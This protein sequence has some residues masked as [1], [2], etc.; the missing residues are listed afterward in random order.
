MAILTDGFY[1]LSVAFAIQLES[2]T[3]HAAIQ[4][5]PW[6][7][8]SPRFQ[9]KHAVLAVYIAGMALAAKSVTRPEYTP[10]MYA[11]L[12]IDNQQVGF[13]K[14]QLRQDS[15]SGVPNSTVSLINSVNSTSTRLFAR[16]DGETGVQDLSGVITDHKDPKLTIKYNIFG[17]HIPIVEISSVFLDAMAT[18]ARPDMTATDAYVNSL[19]ISATATV[20]VHQVTSPLSWKHLIRTVTLLWEMLASGGKDHEIDF[21]MFYDGIQ[22]G[23]GSL[24]SSPLSN[25][26]MVSSG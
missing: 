18:A 25:T 1:S 2:P 4:V 12:F 11:G 17:E 13:L 26:G 6:P 24:M 5:V 14:W 21:E 23:E 16:S 9:G 3:Y 8:P 7:A 19:S 10:E 22:I 20:N 15:V